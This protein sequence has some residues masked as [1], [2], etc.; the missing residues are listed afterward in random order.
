MNIFYVDTDPRKAAEALVDKHVVKMI[1]ETAQLLSTAHRVLDED[2]LE[3]ARD[4]ILYKATHKNHPCAKW[5]RESVENYNW[6][7][8]HLIALLQEYS[9][10]YDKVHKVNGELSAI[11][12]SPPYNLREWDFTE[13]PTAMPDEYIVEG[14]P[15]QSYRNYYANAKKHLHAW[16]KRTPPPW[17]GEAYGFTNIE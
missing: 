13:P 17:I 15:V 12:S 1:L 8:D 16:K 2:H 3:P 9:I 4:E 10:R 7:Y 14:D 5:V 6:A 11:L